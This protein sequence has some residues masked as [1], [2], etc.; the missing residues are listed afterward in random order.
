MNLKIFNSTVELAKTFC[1]HLKKM[2]EE[3]EKLYVALSGGSTPGIIFSLLADE[4]QSSIKWNKIHF[5]WGD[6]RMVPP[7]HFESNFGTTKYKLFDHLNIPT[8]NI[9]RIFGENDPEKESV[10]YSTEIKNLVPL[11]KTFPQF[12]LMMLGLGEDGHTAS[13]FPDQMHLLTS[14]NICEVA[15]HPNSKQKR[16]TLTGQ[17]INNA[18]EIYFLVTGTSKQ[19]IIHDIFYG[20]DNLKYPAVH[21]KTKSGNMNYYLDNDASVLIQNKDG[22]L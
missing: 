4:Y 17:V 14:E 19:K 11:K 1:D 20:K 16:I 15:V 8:E 18:S 6:E 10:R 5:F 12:D 3:K 21:I 13:I 2:S 9:H 7:E 22:S